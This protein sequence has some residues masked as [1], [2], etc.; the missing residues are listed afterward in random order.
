MTPNIAIGTPIQIHL[1]KNGI[2]SVRTGT[3]ADITPTTIKLQKQDGSYGT[4][5]KTEINLY[6]R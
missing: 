6:S 2:D 3:L 4:Y 5:K 1:T